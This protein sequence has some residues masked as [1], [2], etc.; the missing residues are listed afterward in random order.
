MQEPP[1]DTIRI[2]I[3]T[4][5]HLGLRDDDPI[6]GNDSFIAFEEIL[7]LA[8]KN[9]ADFLLLGGDLFDHNKPS[10][11]TL[12]KAMELFR[13]Y[14]FGD[15]Q[16]HFQV[17]N[18]HREH[19]FISN[20]GRL[21][22]EDPNI[23]ISLPVFGI[24]GN[25]DE[26][27]GQNS[28]SPMDMLSVNNLLNYF[29]KT[30]KDDEVKVAPILIKKGE[31]ILAL[32]GLGYIKDERYYQLVNNKHLTFLFHTNENI[33][34]LFTTHQN[35]HREFLGNKNVIS[36]ENLPSQFD[37]ILWGHEHGCR[38]DPEP[39]KNG[40]HVIQPGSSVVVGYRPEESGDKKIAILD[41]TKKKYTLT[42]IT[43]KCRRPFIYE[44][45]HI[46]D[47][48]D[49]EIDKRDIKEITRILEKKIEYLIEKANLNLP[50]QQVL[51][52]FP[53][54]SLPII[55]LVIDYSPEFETI[56]PQSFGK[57]FEGKVANCKDLLIFSR[58]NNKKTSSKDQYEDSHVSGFETVESLL[59]KYMK[60]NNI[61]LNL[62]NEDKLL[63][64][65]NDYI[66]DEN[67]KSI[68]KF[69]KNELEEIQKKLKYDLILD[70]L[71]VDII[72]DKLK[73]YKIHSEAHISLNG[74]SKSSHK[75]N[76]YSSSSEDKM[77]EEEES[78]LK[79]K[80]VSDL[81]KKNK[82]RKI[83]NS[84]KKQTSISNPINLDNLSDD[85]DMKK[86]TRSNL[87]T[88]WGQK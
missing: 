42:P 33:F 78:D 84:S 47:L 7:N 3:A 69:V 70:N 55:R 26:P 75:S 76:N 53:E 15:D 73:S 45:V 2:C 71:N 88:K 50:P 46:S 30:T 9:K 39:S 61:S 63:N 66:E 87:G 16:V 41:I 56:A 11:E 65:V 12:H 43:L 86:R 34:N 22:Y 36:E 21:N 57:R 13:K 10:R 31:T 79:R 44:R 20:Q 28:L 27:S 38:I 6:L 74:N 77:S 59:N 64:A 49:D 5:N 72:N 80:R 19:N 24:H 83:E 23:N 35:R 17:L 67:K 54:L 60:E 58:K 81:K 82:R 48:L 18:Y 1:Q 40:F 25:H 14:C 37:L 4:D 51:D 32:Y 29:G 52:K 85:G 68:E 62:L 8:K